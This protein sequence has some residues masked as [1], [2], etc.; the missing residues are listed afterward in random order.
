MPHLEP[1]LLSLF[2]STSASSAAARLD[3]SPY[4]KRWNARQQQQGVERRDSGASDNSPND[5]VTSPATAPAAD[6]GR[7]DEV[8]EDDDDMGYAVV[9]RGTTLLL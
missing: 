9:R 3:G 5:M 7:Q 6:G 2:R 4:I 8:D 1:P